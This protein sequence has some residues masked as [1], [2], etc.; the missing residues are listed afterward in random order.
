MHVVCSTSVAEMETVPQ[1]LLVVNEPIIRGKAKRQVDL[2]DHIIYVAKL[3][4]GEACS[5]FTSRS[6]QKQKKSSSFSKY[7]HIYAL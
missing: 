5:T 2:L 1:S 7:F 3:F 4:H 6:C